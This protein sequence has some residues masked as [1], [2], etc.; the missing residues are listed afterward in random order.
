MR[1]SQMPSDRALNLLIV[2]AAIIT[3]AA[4]AG[5]IQV[6]SGTGQIGLVTWLGF[7][8]GPPCLIPA[9]VELIGGANRPPPR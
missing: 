5:L 9:M 6:L 7:A 4:L 8:W 2:G 3:L 1:T